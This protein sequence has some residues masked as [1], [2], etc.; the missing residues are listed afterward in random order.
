MKKLSFIFLLMYSVAVHAQ[1]YSVR[2][3][4]VKEDTVVNN[5]MPT[6]ELYQAGKQLKNAALYQGMSIAFAAAGS[7]SLLTMTKD[8]NKSG[9]FLAGIGYVASLVCQY[10]SWNAIFKS[11]KKIEISAN[12]I[13]IN[14]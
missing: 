4:G 2:N 12:K 14:L 10:F 3:Q 13:A 6:I 1:T 11:G 5:N 9:Y 8:E 7:V